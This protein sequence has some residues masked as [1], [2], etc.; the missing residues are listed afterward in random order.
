[1]V[2][3][4]IQM[5]LQPSAVYHKMQSVFQCYESGIL[6]GQKKRQMTGVKR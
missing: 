5:A 4:A 3:P 6:K 1:M 2:D